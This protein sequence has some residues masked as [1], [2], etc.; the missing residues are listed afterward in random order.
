VWAHKPR[1]PIVCFAD[2][3]IHTANKASDYY[4][5]W[6][7][8]PHSPD[9]NKHAE[10]ALGTMLRAFITWLLETRRATSAHGPL[11]VEPPAFFLA[12]LNWL[13]EEGA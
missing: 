3:K 10:H 8:P 7:H 12:N 1:L 11:K 13:F 6:E 2:P 4:S 9:F 5:T